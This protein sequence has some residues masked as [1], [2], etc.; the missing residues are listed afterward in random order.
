MTRPGD[1]TLL[2]ATAAHRPLLRRLYELYSHDFSPM[3]GSDI[4]E[5]GWWTDEA[6]LAEWPAF[7]PD[8]YLFQVGDRWA[9]FAWIGRGSYVQ[10]GRAEHHLVEEFFILRKYRRRGL[11]AYFAARLFDRYPGTWEVGEIVENTAAIAFWRRVIGDYTGGRFQEFTAD[12]PRWQ[13]PVQVFTSA[14][15]RPSFAPTDKE[16]C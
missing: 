9:G 15:P 2:P 7:G 1:L 14:G 16:L 12:N 8:I 4:G 11:G 13:G 10:L 6:F 5:D 3:T